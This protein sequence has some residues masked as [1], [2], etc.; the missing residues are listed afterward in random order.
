MTRLAAV[1]DTRTPSCLS[2]P[3]V[4]HSF[5]GKKKNKNKIGFG[6]K[7][8]PAGDVLPGRSAEAD[9][10][11]SSVL[12]SPSQGQTSRAGSD[13]STCSHA[14]AAGSGVRPSPGLAL[15][16]ELAQPRTRSLG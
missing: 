10:C 16:A 4:F 15:Q 9:S 5:L 1:G 11:A 12:I 13:T 2:Q 6:R 3:K 8:E 7:A 14:A